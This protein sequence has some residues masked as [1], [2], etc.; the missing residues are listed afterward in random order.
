MKQQVV[1]DHC[2]AFLHALL[3]TT[4]QHLEEIANDKDVAQKMQKPK[5]HLPILASEFR[6]RMAKGRTFD[7]HGAYRRKFYDIVLKRAEKVILSPSLKNLVAD[8]Y[9][10]MRR[11]FLTL[12]DQPQ[13]CP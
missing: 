2:H 13:N 7:A 11:P 5:D 9:F 6:D 8:V 12:S 1:R 10:R 3:S 4:R